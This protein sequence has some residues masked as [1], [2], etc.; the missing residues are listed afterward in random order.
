MSD[1]TTDTELCFLI[2]YMCKPPKN[3]DFPKNEQLFRFV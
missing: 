1:E 2:T 3:F